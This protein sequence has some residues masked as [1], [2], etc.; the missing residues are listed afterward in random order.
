MCPSSMENILLCIKTLT[1]ISVLFGGLAERRAMTRNREERIEVS[2]RCLDGASTIVPRFT[3]YSHGVPDILGRSSVQRLSQTF[4]SAPHSLAFPKQFSWVQWRAVEVLFAGCVSSDHP[5]IPSDS[6]QSQ[7][8]HHSRAPACG[9][10]DPTAPRSAS[11]ERFR[12]LKELRS[13]S[14]ARA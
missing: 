2:G 14:Q 10:D 12:K 6:P 3:S 4:A 8:Q 9:R 5:N 11:F 7:R 1:A 13:R